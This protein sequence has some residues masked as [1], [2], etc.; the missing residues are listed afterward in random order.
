MTDL[1]IL[2]DQARLAEAACAYVL[3]RAHA[4]IAARGRFTLAL[5]GGSTPKL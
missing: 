3:A 1:C 4:A 5:T 2:P